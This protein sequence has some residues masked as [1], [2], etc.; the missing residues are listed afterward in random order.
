MTRKLRFSANMSLLRRIARAERR[1]W[2]TSAYFVP[3]TLVTLALKS[4]ASRGV[5]V[6]VLVPQVSDVFFVPWLTRLYSVFLISFGVRFFEYVPSVLH[7][8]SAIIDD[9]TFVGSS[10]F[11]HRSFIHDLELDVVLSRPESINAMAAQFEKDCRLSSESK[12]GNAHKGFIGI[13]ARLL[14]RFRR[15]S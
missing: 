2:I 4:A 6:R 8:K 14:W 10:N 7:A 1:I 12:G 3:R 15:Y 11:N 9:W 13:I 5:D